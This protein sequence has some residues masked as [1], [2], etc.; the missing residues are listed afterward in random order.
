[1]PENANELSSP[2]AERLKRFEDFL[3]FE[4]RRS[5]HTVRNYVKATEA[6]LQWVGESDSGETMSPRLVRSYVVEV[7]RHYERRTIHN[8]VSGMRVFFKWLRREGEIDGNPMLGVRLPKL[9]RPLPVHLTELQIKALL[10]APMA[11]LQSEQVSP[12]EAW[13]DTLVLEILYGGGLRIGELCGLKVKDVDASAGVVRVMGKGSKERVCPVGVVAIQVYQ[14]Y[15]AHYRGVCAPD[16][17]V[18][19]RRNGESLSPRTIQARLKIYLKHAGL[20]MDLTPHKLRHSFATHL[21]DHG[22]DLRIVQNMLGHASLSSTQIYTHVGVSRL[23]KAHAQ[24]HP[25]A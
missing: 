10:D 25:R 17:W 21:L 8:H 24:A 3:A 9:D 4:E 6:F 18:F 14:H 20:P 11:L 15:L 5:K 1:M 22:A 23:K 2:W 7:Q 16:S 13:R 19:V 12:L